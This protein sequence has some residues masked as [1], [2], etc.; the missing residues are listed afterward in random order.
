[1]QVDTRTLPAVPGDRF[2]LCSDGLHGYLE[3]SEIAGFATGDVEDAASR[4]VEVANRRGG[5]DNITAIVVDLK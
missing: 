3:D 1:V 4:A 2:L 5:R